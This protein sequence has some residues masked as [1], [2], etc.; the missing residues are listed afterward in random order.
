MVVGL[1]REAAI[2]K[3]WRFEVRG[4]AVL[5]WVEEGRGGGGC[6]FGAVAIFGGWYRLLV[7]E[8]GKE[9]DGSSSLGRAGSGC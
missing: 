6:V 2:S 9:G 7:F 5:E 4:E 8:W 1:L 3:G